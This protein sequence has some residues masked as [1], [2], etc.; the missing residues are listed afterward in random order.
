MKYIPYLTSKI[1][2]LSG[3]THQYDCIFLK[4]LAIKGR[5]DLLFFESKWHAQ[6]ILGDRQDVMVFNQKAFDVYYRLRNEGRNVDLFRIFVSSVPLRSDAF[7]FCLAYGILP[8]QPY[9]PGRTLEPI[10]VAI[11]ELEKVIS[12]NPT[13]RIEERSK[14]IESLHRFREK[15]FWGCS[16]IGTGVMESGDVLFNRY[17]EL[18]TRKCQEVS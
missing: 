5:K 16:S 12:N 17:R 2:G 14:L 3:V 7:R 18:V 11:F 8:I 10:E 15:I 4:R 6:S 1:T 9:E 13:E